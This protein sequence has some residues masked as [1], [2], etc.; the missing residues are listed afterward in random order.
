MLYKMANDWFAI[1]PVFCNLHLVTSAL[2][3][4]VENTSTRPP[5]S[6]WCCPCVTE[7]TSKFQGAWSLQFK[8]QYY[9]RIKGPQNKVH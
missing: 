4:S 5:S 3:D 6:L 2:P 9:Q 8:I 7:E 1:T